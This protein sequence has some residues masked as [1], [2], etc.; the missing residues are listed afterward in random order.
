MGRPQLV[1][2]RLRFVVGKATA[3]A[4]GPDH[5]PLWVTVR[6]NH[7]VLQD[8]PVVSPVFRDDGTPVSLEE[9]RCH[10]VPIL[11]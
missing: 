3:I 10:C 7:S 11:P 9:I 1:F 5:T 2:P 8:V 4:I 6:Q